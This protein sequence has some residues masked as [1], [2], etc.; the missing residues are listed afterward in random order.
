M[1]DLPAAY[2]KYCPAMKKSHRAGFA[3]LA[4]MADDAK[5]R[6][7]QSIPEHGLPR[8]RY[9]CKDTNSLTR[10]VIDYI[11]LT[12]GYAVRIQSQGQYDSKRGIWRKGTTR[13]G[14]ADIIAAIRGRFV[15]IEIKTGRD[16]QSEAQRRTETDVKQAGGIYWVIRNFEGFLE[17]M[18]KID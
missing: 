9:S 4:A 13:K 7:F 14:T 12:G 15:S 18:E 16:K 1:H 10:A 6:K 2:T 3:E 5:R 8:S 11:N 17:Q